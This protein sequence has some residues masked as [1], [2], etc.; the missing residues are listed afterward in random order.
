MASLGQNLPAPILKD[1]ARTEILS[2]IG[3]THRSPQLPLPRG[4]LRFKLVTMA[5]KGDNVLKLD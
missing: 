2:S 4:A 1:S 5:E 3:L